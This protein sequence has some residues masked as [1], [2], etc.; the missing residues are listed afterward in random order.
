MSNSGWIKLHRALL[1]NPVVMKDAEHLAIWT[2]LL[3]NATH[4]GTDVMFH[5]KRITLKP[6]ELTTGRQRIAKALKI[7]E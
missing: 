4:N 6:G 2:W 5:G 3:L 7:S 1:D